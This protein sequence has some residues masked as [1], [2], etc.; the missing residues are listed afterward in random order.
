MDL[1]AA[2][3]LVLTSLDVNPVFT[4]L[5]RKPLMRLGGQSL[6]TLVALSAAFMAYRLA[7]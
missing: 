4:T 5:S 7:P 2:L 3:L 1:G 6:V